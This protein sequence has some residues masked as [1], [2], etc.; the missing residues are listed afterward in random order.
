MTQE[1]FMAAVVS[2][3]GESWQEHDDVVAHVGEELRKLTDEQQFRIL[4]PIAVK[5][6]GHDFPVL[7]AAILLRRLSPECPISCDEAVRALLPEWDI[8]IEQVPFYLAARFGS[9]RVREAVR[10][11]E[12]EATGKPEKATLNTIIYWAGV[13]D[14]SCTNGS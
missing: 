14:E 5:S 13:Y 3:P 1:Q 11:I 12:Q 7:D 4:F 6:Q 9:K 2:P 8:S 10:N